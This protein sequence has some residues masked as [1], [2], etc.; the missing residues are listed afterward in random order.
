MKNS[1]LGLILAIA[2]FIITLWYAFYVEGEQ[3]A[4]VIS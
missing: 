2:S 1:I 3:A 4:M